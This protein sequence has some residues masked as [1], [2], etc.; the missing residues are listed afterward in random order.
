MRHPMLESL[1]SLRLHRRMTT[2]K[3]EKIIALKN[4]QP[5]LEE[6]LPPGELISTEILSLS[7]QLM[8]LTERLNRQHTHNQRLSISADYIRYPQYQL[9]TENRA[10]RKASVT[11]INIVK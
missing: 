6:I 11:T 2:E 4:K 10:K 8:A 1:S 7:D 5:S 9:A 3:I